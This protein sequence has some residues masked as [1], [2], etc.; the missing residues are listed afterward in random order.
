M[1]HLAKNGSHT[2]GGKCEAR[3]AQRHGEEFRKLERR[4]PVPVPW[5]LDSRVE[6]REAWTERGRCEENQEERL[7][8]VPMWW[9]GAPGGDWLKATIRPW[10]PPV[11]RNTSGKSGRSNHGTSSTNPRIFY[12]FCPFCPLLLTYGNEGSQKLLTFGARHRI[13]KMWTSA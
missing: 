5:A 7:Y 3:T 11:S 1:L 13:V 4:V 10:R 2:R 6:R 9:L 8:E 12:R